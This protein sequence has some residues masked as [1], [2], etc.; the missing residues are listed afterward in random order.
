MPLASS[1][2][3]MYPIDEEEEKRAPGSYCANRTAEYIEDLLKENP[4][5]ARAYVPSKYLYKKL[6]HID[7]KVIYRQYEQPD[8]YAIELGGTACK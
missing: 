6:S 5:I 2:A 3:S 7:S 4:C 1:N 8:R